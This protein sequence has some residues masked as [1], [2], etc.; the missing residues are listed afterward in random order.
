MVTSTPYYAQANGQVEVANKILINLIKKQIVLPLEINLNTLR[1]LRKDD[2]PI[3]YY[4]NVVYDE[5]SD[6]S[7]ECILALEN[8]VRQKD[9]ITQNHN[10][11]IKKKCFR[12]GKLVLKVILPTEKKS[13]FLGKWSHNWE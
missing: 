3:E 4:W 9:N 8:I 2:L 7:Q 12:M 13:K 5:L 10:R 1:I 11:R 6:L